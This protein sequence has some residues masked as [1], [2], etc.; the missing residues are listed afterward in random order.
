MAG[1]EVWEAAENGV[2]NS[3]VP[4]ATNDCPSDEGPSEARDDGDSS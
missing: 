3:N 4:P 1:S 2:P